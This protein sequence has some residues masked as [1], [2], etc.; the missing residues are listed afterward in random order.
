MFGFAVV[1]YLALNNSDR[2]FY[3]YEKDESVFTHLQTQ[4]ENPYFFS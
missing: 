2:E 4:R 1:R 3:L